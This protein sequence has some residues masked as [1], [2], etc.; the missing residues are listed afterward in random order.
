MCMANTTITY[1]LR[2]PESSR[3]MF[4][5]RMNSQSNIHLRVE[6]CHCEERSDEAISLSQKGRQ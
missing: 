2:L 4:V 3:L 5:R 6:D 1:E